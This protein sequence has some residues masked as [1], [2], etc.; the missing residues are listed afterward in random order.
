[1]EKGAQQA[2]TRQRPRNNVA[3]DNQY[4]YQPKKTKKTQD[5]AKKTKHQKGK[6]ERAIY[7]QAVAPRRAV[8]DYEQTRYLGTDQLNHENHHDKE[9]QDQLNHENH[10]GKELGKKEG[11]NH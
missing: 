7:N 10:H 3:Q 4:Q 9:L 6:K 5:P 2:A 8:D 11:N 1:T